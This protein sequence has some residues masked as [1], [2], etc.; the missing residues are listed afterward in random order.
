MCVFFATDDYDAFEFNAPSEPATMTLNMKYC[1]YLVRPC[2]PIIDQQ[3]PG[4]SGLIHKEAHPL[5]PYPC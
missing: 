1:I 2:Q 3:G 5:A 4:L